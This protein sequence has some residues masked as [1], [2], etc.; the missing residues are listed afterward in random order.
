MPQKFKLGERFATV[1]KRFP[2]AFAFLGVLV[3]AAF[4]WGADASNEEKLIPTLWYCFTAAFLSVAMKLLR[5]EKTGIAAEIV[6]QVA[7]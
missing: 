5:E 2:A 6:L 4:A 3:I 7:L 1:F